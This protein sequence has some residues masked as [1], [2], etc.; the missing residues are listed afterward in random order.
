MRGRHEGPDMLHLY[1][2]PPLEDEGGS[3]AY[4]CVP[5]DGGIC[6]RVV[7]GGAG[8]DFDGRGRGEQFGNGIEM[9]AVVH[10]QSMCERWVDRRRTGLG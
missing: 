8:E 10:V 4:V 7:P 2:G 3:R 5:W 1:A 9:E 6:A